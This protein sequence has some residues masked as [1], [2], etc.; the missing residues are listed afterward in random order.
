MPGVTF[1]ERAR[2]SGSPFP[3]ICPHSG[4]TAVF[5]ELIKIRHLLPNQELGPRLAPGIRVDQ[6]LSK[7]L[8]QQPEPS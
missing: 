1:V 7:R 3:R 8:W 2:M 5:A 6:L 4:F